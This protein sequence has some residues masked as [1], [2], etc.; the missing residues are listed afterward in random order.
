VVGVAVLA[1]PA[2]PDGP[3]T[4]RRLLELARE[5]AVVTALVLAYQ[6]ARLFGADR[7]EVAFAHA[8]RLWQVEQ[9]LHLPREQS[10]QEFVSQVPQLV[11]ALNAYYAGVHFPLTFSVLLWLFLRHRAH[12]AWARR[13][14]FAATG[15]GLVLQLALPVAPPRMRHDLGFVDTALAY[16]QSVYG[17]PGVHSL[18]NQY[19]AMPSLHVGW[20]VLVAVVAIHA[21]RSRWRWLW[22]L[23]PAI[24]L[25]VV[26]AT[27]NHWWLDSLIGSAV[28]VTALVVCLPRHA[29]IWHDGGRDHA[30][31]APDGP[32]GLPAPCVSLSSLTSSPD[33]RAAPAPFREPCDVPPARQSCRNPS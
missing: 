7:V 23:H 31:P 5:A 9:W 24:T 25:L 29:P 11:K 33:D 17:T 14:L 21:L 4:R 15:A 30:A 26:V 32:S 10:L 13:S 12:Y 19:A 22:A 2:L 18:S 1:V 20:A 8:S 16:G 6:V 3:G 28:V 27:A